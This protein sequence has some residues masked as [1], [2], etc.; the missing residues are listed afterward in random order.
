MNG[1]QENTPNPSGWTARDIVRDA[2]APLSKEQ[3][4]RLPAPLKTHPESEN[5][6]IEALL[7]DP[8]AISHALGLGLTADYFTEFVPR[9]IFRLILEAYEDG[10]PTEFRALTTLAQSKFNERSQEQI[11]ADVTGALTRLGIGGPV[12]N[13]VMEWHLSQLSE[14]KRQRDV[15]AT[16]AKIQ[17]KAELGDDWQ[18]EAKRLQ[19]EFS[20][21]HWPAIVDVHDITGARRPPMPPV[22]VDNLLHRGSKLLIGGMSKGRKTWVLTDLAL[23]VAAGVSWWG[24]RTHQGK[25]LYLNFEIDQA[26]FGYRLEKLMEAKNLRPPTGFLR[27]WNLRGYTEGIEKMAPFIIQQLMGQDYSLIIVDPVYK[28]LGDRDENKAGDIASLCNELERIAVKTKAAIAFGAHFS[29]GNQAGKDAVDRVGG[30]GV[31]ARDPDAILTMTA[32]EAEDC[33]TVDSTLRNFAP[34]APFVVKWDFPLFQ[35][36]EEEDPTAIKGGKAGGGGAAGAGRYGRPGPKKDQLDT[37]LTQLGPGEQ[38]TTDQLRARAGEAM[39]LP[40]ST[41]FRWWKL[42]EDQGKVRMT[43]GRKWV[44][45]F[46]N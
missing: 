33:Y 37:L 24:R 41:F 9:E 1:S 3:L 20:V 31:F 2:P 22:L 10:A 42:L 28:A 23:S 8:N 35:M 15:I 32:H 38:L 29:K 44:R 25:V 14:C 45:V 30:S 11:L 5:A 27:I 21:S 43:E 26:F 4:A 7:C 13:A 16:A 34:V 18:E 36:A 17:K 12:G 6:V 39:Q 46:T 19:E 40:R